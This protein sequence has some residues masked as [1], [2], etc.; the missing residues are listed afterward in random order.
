MNDL[1]VDKRGVLHAV[2]KGLRSIC[3]I[4]VADLIPFA[5]STSVCPKCFGKDASWDEVA[6]AV[7]VPQGGKRVGHE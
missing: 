6:K 7:G 3:G 4:H 5:S 2:V 1:M